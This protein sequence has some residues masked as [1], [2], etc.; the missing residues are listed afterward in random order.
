MRALVKK[1][2]LL[3]VPLGGGKYLCRGELIFN[4]CH[5]SGDIPGNSIAHLW[6]RNIGEL[7][8]LQFIML[9]I[10]LELLGVFF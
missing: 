3:M 7:L 10:I 4:P 9:V 1:K 6:G 5:T 2:K 8:D